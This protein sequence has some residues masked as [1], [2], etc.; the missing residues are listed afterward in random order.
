MERQPGRNLTA[1]F[2]ILWSF[3]IFVSV[4]DGYLAIRHRHEILEFE[5]NPLGRVLLHQGG[6]ITGLVVAKF[7]GTVLACALLVVLQRTSPRL[8]LIVVSLLAALQFAL[9]LYLLL[10]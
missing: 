7:V 2:W 4:V 3:I 6:G 10:A 5:M 9:L 8:N 1:M